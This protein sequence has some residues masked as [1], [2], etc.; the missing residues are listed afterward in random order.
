MGNDEIDRWK[1]NRER[2]DET[3]KGRINLIARRRDK[4]RKTTKVNTEEP[5]RTRVVKTWDRIM[6]RQ[7]RQREQV[8]KASRKTRMATRRRRRSGVDEENRVWRNPE[9]REMGPGAGEKAEDYQTIQDE[10]DDE[11][12]MFDMEQVRYEQT[13]NK[14]RT[15]SGSA[16][17][18]E[19][20]GRMFG[21]ERRKRRAET[22]DHG[23]TSRARN[24]GGRGNYRNKG[25]AGRGHGR[26][27]RGR[28]WAK[29]KREEQET[30][31][32]R[33]YRKTLMKKIQHAEKAYCENTNENIRKIIQQ[34]E[35]EATRAQ[36]DSEM[37][38]WEYLLPD[39][40]NTRGRMTQYKQTLHVYWTIKRLMAKA[41][42]QVAMEMVEM[43]QESP[44]MKKEMHNIKVT[45][46]MQDKR[47]EEIQQQIK[48]ITP[49]IKKEEDQQGVGQINS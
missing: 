33:K 40:G 19:Q 15:G 10:T 5:Q 24:R 21:D 39:P 36:S 17:D 27:S 26:G 48:R 35:E 22:G 49:D 43:S 30:A 23:S 31:P 4:G 2:E 25:R 32:A 41:M 37:E 34:M 7:R 16:K 18:K 20:E 1:K 47:L 38:D 28:R 29:R 6:E 12:E 44:Y 9:K 14:E 45:L 13:R 3:G 46:I 11:V 8:D 42:E